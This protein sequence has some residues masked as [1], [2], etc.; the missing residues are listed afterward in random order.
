[1]IDVAAA[2]KH[3]LGDALGLSAFGNGLANRLGRGQIPA[4]TP[5]SLFA[6][7][8]TRRDQGR[9]LKIVNQLHVDVIQRPVY[10]QPRTLRRALD[11][12]A[13]ALMHMPP[14]CILGLMGKHKFSFLRNPS[15]HSG[16][17]RSLRSRLSNLLLQS[18]A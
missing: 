4:S 9:T 17:S 10:I 6:Y 18:L 5:F 16:G 14:G 12:L 13:N 15:L 8:R 3:N 7:G 1:M 11:F 2:V